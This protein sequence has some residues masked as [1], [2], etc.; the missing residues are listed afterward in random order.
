MKYYLKAMEKA[1]IKAFKTDNWQQ[2]EKLENH[3][4]NIL[5][6]VYSQLLTG[7][8]KTAYQ[9]TKTHLIIAH[10]S[11]RKGVL[12]QVSVACFINGELTPLMHNNVNS[13]AEYL[14]KNEFYLAEYIRTT[15]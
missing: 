7:E 9:R 12:I 11:T 15:A 1:T 8:I 3:N 5:A 14:K 4:N 6:S 13:F 2:V 10:K